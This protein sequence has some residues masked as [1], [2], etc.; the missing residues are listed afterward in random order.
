MMKPRKIILG[1]VALLLTL[2]FLGLVPRIYQWNK[3][4]KD[5]ISNEPSVMVMEA[6]PSK[7]AIELVLP[8]STEALHITPIWARS[9]GYL[10]KLNV[11]IGDVVEEGQ[12]LGVIDTPEIEQEYL[13]AKAN[14][15]SA[16]ARLEIAKISAERWQKLYDSNN[17]AVSFQEVDER[18]TTLTA[19]EADV[20]AN[21][22]NV[23][24]LEKILSF[25]KVSAPFKGIII[26]RN[27]DIGSL[28]SAGSNG[29]PQQLFK[30]ADIDIIRVF[31]EV[32]QYYYRSIS[33]GVPADVKIREFPGHNFKG[34]VVRYAKAL[35]P[36]ARTLLTEVNIDNKDHLI[37]AGLYA[38]VSF[39][40]YPE[41]DY[42][43]VPTQA[44][45]IR[46]Q[47][48][49]IALL[50]E[51]SQVKIQP[52]QLGRDWGRTIEVIK[53][54]APGDQIITNPTDR[55]I[56]GIKVKKS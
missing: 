30:I 51:N 14:L 44:I 8:S 20:K 4:Q 56:N 41:T 1:A 50:D 21:A 48:P 5:D 9:N 36:V 17:E 27:I 2:F 12:I 45:I 7:K 29:S 35:D 13:Q 23:E 52:V 32:P 46:N 49:Q 18:R 10:G 11:D 3:I 47:A 24:R 53:G 6:V 38:D 22:A 39:T 28:I 54:I 26:E 33:K 19:A 16:A 40:L 55:I 25:N 31:V 37:T 15:N 42:F 43:V 34:K